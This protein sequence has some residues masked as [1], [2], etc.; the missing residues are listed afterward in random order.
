MLF[1]D[2]QTL[3]ICQ[4]CW[5]RKRHKDAAAAPRWTCSQAPHKSQLLVTNSVADKVLST[6]IGAQ[7]QKD[8]A[9]LPAPGK[10]EMSKRETNKLKTTKKPK[11]EYLRAG[12]DTYLHSFLH[13]TVQPS[14]RARPSVLQHSPCPWSAVCIH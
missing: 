10:I 3:L 2:L 8:T 4:C 9:F 7:C 11:H 12:L 1:L 6:G 14:H 5:Q 13:A